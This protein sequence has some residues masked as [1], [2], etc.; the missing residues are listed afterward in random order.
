MIVYHILSFCPCLFPTKV[1]QKT[2][3]LECLKSILIFVKRC[4]V[5]V[6]RTKYI[7]HI[8]IYWMNISN[9]LKNV[10]VDW[11]V[12]TIYK[13]NINYIYF[14]IIQT[15]FFRKNGQH[16]PAI[17]FRVDNYSGLHMSL[18]NT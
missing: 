14:R 16:F 8:L 13:S 17:I 6:S 1:T 2:I 4:F 11:N 12:G 3:N 10:Y 5:C 18:S 7:F 15:H 9:V